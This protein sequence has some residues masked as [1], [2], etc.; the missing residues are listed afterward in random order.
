MSQKEDVL[1]C[2]IA[3][4]TGLVSPVQAQKVLAICNKREKEEGRRP[5]IG[6]V[7]S[8]YNLMQTQEVQKIYEAV[9]KRTGGAMGPASRLKNARSE[10]GSTAAAGRRGGGGRDRARGPGGRAPAAKQ[11]YPQT[12]WLGIGFGV[13]F[14]GVVITILVML[15]TP[16][17]AS[18]KGSAEGTA[19]SD[20]ADEFDES[21][22]SAGASGAAGRG[23]GQSAA[24]RPRVDGP[25][26]LSRDDEQ[27]VRDRLGDARRDIGED[28][29]RGLKIVA[30][31]KD[32]LEKKKASGYEAGAWMAQVKDV[33]TELREALAGANGASAAGAAPE[34][35]AEPGKPA[36]PGTPA[37]P[38]PGKPEPG[39]PE[40]KDLGDDFFG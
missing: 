16:P 14:L 34:G 9:N 33:E 30:N 28:P 18:Q 27:E 3:I 1:F 26:D 6:A 5:L 23:A 4:T 17:E 7:F 8:K 36:A 21:G 37:A 15:F 32:F 20:G 12:L 35:A 13:V 22:E 39:K 19:S 2:K 10:R 25:R 11:V 38:E 29:E 40:T 24:D 31:L